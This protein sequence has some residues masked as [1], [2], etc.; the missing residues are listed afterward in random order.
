S[1]P[2][3]NIIIQGGAGGQPAGDAAPAPPPED[4][5]PPRG[6]S[7]QALNLAWRFIGFGDAHFANQNYAEANERYRKAATASPQLADAYFRQAYALM[8]MG[9]YDLAVSAIRRGLSLAPGWPKSGFN[10]AELYGDNPQAKAAHLEALAAAS[11]KDPHN[12]DLLFLV[13]VCL[14]FDGKP[15]RAAPFFERA[16]QL[17]ADDDAHVKAFLMQ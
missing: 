4:P 1:Q 17:L 12:A 11:E 14:H 5:K 2:T 8:A 10:N 6:T 15:E 9:R 3:T 16:D 13:G 7:Q